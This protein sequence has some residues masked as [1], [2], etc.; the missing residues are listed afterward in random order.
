MDIQKLENYIAENHIVSIDLIRLPRTLPINH[1]QDARKHIK[2]FFD[3]HE[4]IRIYGETSGGYCQHGIYKG[5]NGIIYLIFDSITT[6]R[7]Y[8]L[9][10]KYLIDIFTDIVD[11]TSI[12]LN[13][14]PII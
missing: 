2:S 14:M 4:K 10:K 7:I 8:E 5:N 3:C 6:M 12:L 11:G 13:D 1:L 9:S